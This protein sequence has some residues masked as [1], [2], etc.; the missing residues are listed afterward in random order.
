MDLKSTMKGE[1]FRLSLSKAAIAL[2]V[3]RTIGLN[4]QVSADTISGARHVIAIRRAI[5][6]A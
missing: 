1:P 4:L 5:S 6:V 3:V 2:R